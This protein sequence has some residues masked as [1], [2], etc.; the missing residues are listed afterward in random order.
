M[1]DRGPLQTRRDDEIASR[2]R[3]GRTALVM[4][5]AALGL[6][7]CE[8]GAGRSGSS[9]PRA[10]RSSHDSGGFGGSSY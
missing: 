4:L 5:V 6:S 7:A 3:L 8:S 9:D 2:R 10:D 1:A